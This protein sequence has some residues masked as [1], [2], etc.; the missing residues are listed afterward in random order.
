MSGSCAIPALEGAYNGI[1]ALGL[2]F[3]FGGFIIWLP[4]VIIVLLISVG[5]KIYSL[6]R[7]YRWNTVRNILQLVFLLVNL[8]I[9][10]LLIKLFFFP[11][12]IWILFAMI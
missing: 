2:I 8:V 1:N 10:F 6:V 9:L 4:I 3:S 12:G 7:G 11:D 5:I